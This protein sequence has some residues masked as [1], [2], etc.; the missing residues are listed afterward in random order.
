M[1]ILLEDKNW[2]KMNN[3]LL[4][5]NKSKKL[6]QANNCDNT[7]KIEGAIKWRLLSLNIKTKITASN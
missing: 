5:T 2:E 6:D 3:I 7:H 1:V 4:D